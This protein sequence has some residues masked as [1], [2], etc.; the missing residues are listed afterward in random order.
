MTTYYQQWK[1]AASGYVKLYFTDV[2]THDKRAMHKL[3]FP[4]IGA[5]RETG[6]NV[7][8]MD[9]E[10]RTDINKHAVE[11]FTFKP[12]HR[13]FH[14]SNGIVRQVSKDEVMAVWRDYR[15]TV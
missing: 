11:V 2:T 9:D 4:F 15:A 10:P 13:F 14:G 5:M 1:K 12:N 6:T 7:I 3:Q 8:I